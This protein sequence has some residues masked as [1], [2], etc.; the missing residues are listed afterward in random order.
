MP[1]IPDTT[2]NVKQDDSGP[3]W[4]GQNLDF[5][6]QNNQSTESWRFDS[7][8]RVP[9]QEGQ[10]PNLNLCSGVYYIL[11]IKCFF[12]LPQG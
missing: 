7:T 5:I 8:C 2:I 12:M 4:P 1:V 3:D 6:S 11:E 10:S 9:A